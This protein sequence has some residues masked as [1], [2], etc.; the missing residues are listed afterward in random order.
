MKLSP[1][2]FNF[3]LSVTAFFPTWLGV[4]LFKSQILITAL[5]IYILIIIT[6]VMGIFT[7]PI[8]FY[9]GLFFYIL[10]ICLR[11]KPTISY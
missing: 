9:A 5:S 4:E 1:Y 11:K 6:L 8:L 2:Y 10:H 7:F 3:L